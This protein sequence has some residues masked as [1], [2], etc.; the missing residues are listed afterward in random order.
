M[1]RCVVVVD[2]ALAAQAARAPTGTGTVE[3][4]DIMGAPTGGGSSDPSTLRHWGFRGVACVVGAQRRLNCGNPPPTA[5][6]S[7]P[8]VSRLCCT[9]DGWAAA[10]LDLGEENYGTRGD[11]DAH[12]G[13]DR[14]PQS[15]CGRI[16]VWPA[17]AEPMPLSTVRDQY[18]MQLQSRAEEEGLL[19][20]SEIVLP[21]A[22][23]VITMTATDQFMAVIAQPKSPKFYLA[24]RRRE[25]DNIHVVHSLDIVSTHGC[26]NSPVLSISSGDHYMTALH[27]GGSKLF[28][29]CTNTVGH[30]KAVPPDLISAGVSK[31]SSYSDMGPGGAY[32]YTFFWNPRTGKAFVQGRDFSYRLGL[33]KHSYTQF[34]MSWAENPVPITTLND[35][36]VVDI[37]QSVRTAFALSLDGDVYSWGGDMLGRTGSPILPA[38]IDRLPADATDGITPPFT[39]IACSRTQAVAST[40][41]QIVLWRDNST[42]IVLPPIPDATIEHLACS[43]RCITAV[44]RVMW[45]PELHFIML[46]SFKEIVWVLMTCFGQNQS[47][48]PLR[49]LGSAVM[50][51]IIRW[52]SAY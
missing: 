38:K 25:E 24:G 21:T 31:V 44:M 51:N 34:N 12:D 32:T 20:S 39:H 4:D 11:G 42:R 35:V 27:K 16:V 50:I 45:S 28:M 52:L 41:N 18:T 10:L 2:C 37:A 43:D 46:P 9:H 40:S 48:T 17:P 3:V 5:F 14:I 6:M 29:C 22:Q 33:G 49:C 26:V 30:S 15:G 7:W 23:P 36:H 8:R 1:V 19:A 13:G 47:R